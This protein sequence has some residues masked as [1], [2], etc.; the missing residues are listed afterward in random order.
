MVFPLF[1]KPLDSTP[2]WRWLLY[3]PTC[4]RKI[5]CGTNYLCWR[6]NYGNDRMIALHMQRAQ[7]LLLPGIWNPFEAKKQPLPL[8]L[9]SL[10]FGPV[11]ASKS[12]ED[13]LCT[14]LVYW[15][16]SFTLVISEPFTNLVEVALNIF[17]GNV[18]G[19]SWML[20]YNHRSRFTW[21]L[22]R[23]KYSIIAKQIL[24]E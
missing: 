4:T 22:I 9:F 14:V 17:P 18:S 15:H 5:I 20:V 23:V 12:K 10:A 11:V 13:F 7:P 2:V 6:N 8:V 16:H 1:A 19:A 3:V 21:H 24:Y